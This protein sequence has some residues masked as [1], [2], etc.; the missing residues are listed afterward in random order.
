MKISFIGGPLDGETR[1]FLNPMLEIRVP[2]KAPV[3]GIKEPPLEDIIKPIKN[4]SYKLI[5]S[6]YQFQGIET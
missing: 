2:R 5:G 6:H 4:Y 1:E 3:S